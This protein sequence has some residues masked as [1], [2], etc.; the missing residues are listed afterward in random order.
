MKRCNFSRGGLHVNSCEELKSKLLYTN[1]F[2][3]KLSVGGGA[4]GRAGQAGDGHQR[5]QADPPR[6]A[7]RGAR[8]YARR[9]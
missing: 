3:Y 9:R 1:F 5:N 6:Q 2:F 7:E 4:E 8:Q